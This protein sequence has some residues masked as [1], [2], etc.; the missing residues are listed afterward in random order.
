MRC[1]VQTLS[2]RWIVFMLGGVVVA[3]V[4]W[5]QKSHQATESVKQLSDVRGLALR[6]EG[7][8]ERFEAG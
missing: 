5:L 7:I 1:G 6:I 2:Y 3:Y 4:K 8:L